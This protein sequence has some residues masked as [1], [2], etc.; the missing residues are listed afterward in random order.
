[1]CDAEGTTREHVPP[2]SFFPKG[3]RQN[4]FTVPSCPEH[5]NNNSLDVEYVR[6]VIVSHISTNAL[7][8]TWF[9]GTA[10]RSYE[11]SPKL[12]NQTF[13]KITPIIIDGQETVIVECDM[14][15]YE[16][17]L[18]AIA[19]ACYFRNFGKRFKGDWVIFSPS[20]V[21]TEILLQ[22]LADPNE[23]LRA[24]LY[25]LPF[26]DIPTS[27]P[28]VF[29]YSV[30]IEDEPDG[31]YSYRFEFYEGFVVYAIRAPNG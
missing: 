17:I 18:K 19:Y 27:N 6:N 10:L 21:S 3:H 5:N 12:K 8:R 26:T 16:S 15:R 24:A 13:A 20:M 7:A 30:H 31:I 9:Q 2:F 11:R 4:L 29:K 22:G 1:M 28:E 25:G 14:P 23:R